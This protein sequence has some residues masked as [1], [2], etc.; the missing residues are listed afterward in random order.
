[1]RR[2]E[3]NHDQPILVRSSTTKDPATPPRRRTLTWSPTWIGLRGFEE[4]SWSRGCSTRGRFEKFWKI[5][6]FHSYLFISIHYQFIINS[7]SIHY[8]F[9][10]C[11]TSVWHTQ[12]NL[13]QESAMMQDLHAITVPIFAHQEDSQFFSGRLCTPESS[14]RHAQKM[15]R[16]VPR[17]SAVVIMITQIFPTHAL[18]PP[19]GH[20]PCRCAMLLH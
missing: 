20:A 8:Q 1:M 12:T 6:R 16:K 13:S 5:E 9:L 4:L 3:I 2:I 14:L 15:K 11:N 17:R 7:V 18:H 19:C 10:S